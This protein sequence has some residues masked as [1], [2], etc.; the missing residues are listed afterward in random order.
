M[1]WDMRITPQALVGLE[2]VVTIRI[3]VTT[4]RDGTTGVSLRTEQGIIGEWT[5]SRACSV[6]LSPSR[7]VTVLG[8]DAAPRYRVLLPGTLTAARQLSD[9]E[10]EMNLDLEAEPPPTA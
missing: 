2:P 4:I 6:S 1:A 9:T 10:I 5:D 8:Q 7:E 3:A